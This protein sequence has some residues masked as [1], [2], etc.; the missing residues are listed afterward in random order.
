MGQP[1]ME[2]ELRAL[3]QRAEG[4]EHQRGHVPCMRAHHVARGQHDVEVVAADDAAQQQH[5]GQQAQPADGGDGEGH[6]GAAPHVDAV[7]PVA[8]QQEG[9]QAGQL[10]EDHQLDQV[11][12]QDHAQHRAHEGKEESEEPGHRVFGRHVVARVEY[13]Q[14]ADAQH[15]DGEQ[16][17]QAIHAQHEVQSV[18]RQPARFK[19]QHLADAD[20]KIEIG[21][22]QQP[23]ERSAARQAG[24]AVAGMGGQ[25]GDQQ[26]ADKRQ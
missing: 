5:A 6:A 9:R 24:R 10:P 4:D 23:Q 20:P 19:A 26:A 15:Q 12:G 2:G 21:G 16:P 22:Q 1:E 7:M 14:H 25:E 8:D 17:C 18:G 13:D 3:G 11:A